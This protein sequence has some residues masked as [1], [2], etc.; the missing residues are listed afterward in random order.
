MK[1]MLKKVLALSM[2]VTMLFGSLT[3]SSFA[4]S[5]VALVVEG[6]TIAVS[7]SEGTTFIDANNRTQVPVRALAESLGQSVAWSS[8]TQTATIGGTI[9]IKIG[10]SE[11]KTANGSIKMDTAAIVKDGRTYVPVRYI[12]EA[13]GLS[14]TAA[15]DNSGAMTVKLAKLTGKIV[16]AGST[17]SQ[18]LS[19]ELAAAF[20]KQY[21]GVTL[22][23]QGGGSGVGIAAAKSGTCDIGSASRELSSSE[24][25]FTEYIF[26][27]DGVAM[28][29]N[30]SVSVSGLSMDQIRKIFIGEITNWKE[31]GGDDKAIVVVSREAG[32]GTRGAFVELTKVQDSAK[33]DQTTSNAIVQPSTGAVLQTVKNTPDSIGYVSLGSLDSS[34][35]SLMVDDVYC[36]EL[37]VINKSYK[38][39]RPFLYVTYGTE[40]TATKTFLNWVMRSEAQKIV[41]ADFISVT[42]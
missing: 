10:S 33:V 27:K 30:K 3:M 16:I 17:S 13:L 25:G 37:N 2:V 6:K 28:I 1:S 18:T 38:I 12:A 23:V 34:V 19:D 39:S 20:K 4:A 41:S 14:V 35:K 40:S 7:A 11:L 9:I 42:K 31:V 29:A 24:T 22:E 5:K 15:K 36:N 26:A 21:P 32:S 8:S